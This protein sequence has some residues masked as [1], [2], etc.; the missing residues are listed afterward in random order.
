[1]KST[2][3]QIIQYTNK[4]STEILKLCFIVD[5]I[6]LCW[7]NWNQIRDSWDGIISEKNIGKLVEYYSDSCEES[8]PYIELII[9]T[10]RGNEIV[11]HGDYI[12]KNIEG[13]IYSYKPHIFE[14][15]YN[16]IG[17]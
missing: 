17:G 1:M 5:A 2:T 13:E 16:P 10:S 4:N 6:Q 3:V 12:I 14:L 15:M 7:K 9:P 8:R 11:K